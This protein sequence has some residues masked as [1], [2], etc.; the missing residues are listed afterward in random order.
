M[1]PHDLA[2]RGLRQRTKYQST[3][4][5]D[6]S[7]FRNGFDISEPIFTNSGI[8]V[9]IITTNGP[10]CAPVVG[11][12][13]GT[14]NECLGA[15]IHRWG[16]DGTS[17][18]N[19]PEVNSACSGGPNHNMSLQRNVPKP[20][21]WNKPLRTRAGND[22]RI[23]GHDRIGGRKHYGFIFQMGREQFCGWYDNGKATDG[24]EGP[25]DLINV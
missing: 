12:L 5:T 4:E 2:N 24:R 20:F 14:G 18:G 15:R 23:L 13:H 3:S 11:C 1:T 16:L 7:F 8:L 9:D 17:Y 22:V 19:H 25:K 10:G 21:T 6:L